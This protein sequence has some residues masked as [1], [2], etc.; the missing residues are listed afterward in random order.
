MYLINCNMTKLK[1]D[2]VSLFKIMAIPYSDAV[3]VSVL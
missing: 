3:I 1:D 2:G